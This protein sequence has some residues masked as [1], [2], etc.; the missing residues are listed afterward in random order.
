MEPN[1]VPATVHSDRKITAGSRVISASPQQIFDLLADPAQHSV[2]DGSD[3]VLGARESNPDRLSKG[4]KF[5]M[6]MKILVPYKMSST[7]SEFDEPRL[8]EWHHFGGHRWRYE[9]EAVANGTRVTESFNWGVARIPALFYE[10][11]GYPDRHR[12]SIDRTLER[13]EKHFSN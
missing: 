4:A 2:I 7:V 10:T 1:I 11:A 3:S 12:G 8:I 9:L 6:N 13:L 5:G